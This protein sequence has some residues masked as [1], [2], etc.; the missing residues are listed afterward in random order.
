MHN[1]YLYRSALARRPPFRQHIYALSLPLSRAAH[2]FALPSAHSIRR[3][4]SPVTF[5]Q[6][7][8]GYSLQIR[9]H[10]QVATAAIEEFSPAT[11]ITTEGPAAQYTQLVKE[12]ALRDDAHQRKTVKLLQD[13]HDRLQ[14]Y[15][16]P[17]IREIEDDPDRH[18]PIHK[19]KGKD[20]MLSPDF[21][22]IKESEE[23]FLSK[24]YHVDLRPNPEDDC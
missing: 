17:P 19:H 1:I 23:N 18:Q 3:A 22:W 13:L 21:A 6:R 9:S 20:D 15:T 8:C 11:T 16:P 2:T 12:G 10:S 5:N 7:C 4:F 24:V 14:T